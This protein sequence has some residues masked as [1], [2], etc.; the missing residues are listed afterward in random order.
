[1][2]G[3]LKIGSILGITIRLHALLLVLAL[4]LYLDQGP[5]GLLVFGILFGVVLL[6]ELGHSVVAQR[7]GVRVVD[8]TLWPLG[9]V[10]RMAE[11]PES[12]RIE[13]WIASA[14]PAVNFVLAPLGVAALLF[15]GLDPEGIA[16]SAL[17]LFV[18]VNLA[19]GIFNLIP[20]FPTDGGRILRALLALRR[21]WLAATEIAVR[22]GGVVA[23]LCA[24][25]G[26]VLVFSSAAFF[27]LGLSLVFVAVFLWWTGRQE[28]AAVRLRHGISPF[29][30]LAELLRRSMEAATPAAPAR[31]A[32]ETPEGRAGLDE[33]ALEDLE[34][35][36]GSL[37]SWRARREE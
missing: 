1:M 30:A 32:R 26:L 25:S 19:I 10:A 28:L 27:G 31:D 2:F 11:M 23:L 16:A 34:Q 33:R 29:A 21:D 14:G 20:A 36:R 3:S 22:V 18:E 17:E 8:I 5:A 6:H 15:L 12:S 9:G 24:V 7:L 4:V 13:G 35:Y 37:R